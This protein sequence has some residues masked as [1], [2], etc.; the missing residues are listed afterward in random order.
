MHIVPVV[1]SGCGLYV[2]H[3]LMRAAPALMPAQG[4][5][6]A[7]PNPPFY[8]PLLIRRRSAHV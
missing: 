2:A 4:G 1:T 5:R 6:Y 3:A 8:N 7:H